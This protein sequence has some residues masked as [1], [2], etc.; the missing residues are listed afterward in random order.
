MNETQ[1]GNRE[2]ARVGILWRVVV[3]GAHGA[4]QV[5]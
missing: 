4:H 2:R 3:G 1:G 5:M